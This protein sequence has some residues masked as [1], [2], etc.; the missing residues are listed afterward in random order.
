MRRIL[1][2]LLAVAAAVSIAAVSGCSRADA[3]AQAGDTAV[4]TEMKSAALSG[5]EMGCAATCTVAEAAAC[6]EVGSPEKTC[7]AT[8]AGKESHETAEI[9]ACEALCA[10]V[11]DLEA[12]VAACPGHQET[13]AAKAV[14]AGTCPHADDD[15]CTCP[16]VAA[17]VTASDCG[18]KADGTCPRT[19]AHC[20]A[21]AAAEIN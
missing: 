7:P 1:A 20:P 13:D 8:M 2:L 3:E 14:V 11:E 15:E 18:R 17:A 9:A 6:A 19:D 16:A 4:S 12:C 10:G 5:E 21:S